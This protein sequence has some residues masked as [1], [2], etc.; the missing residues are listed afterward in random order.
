MYDLKQKGEEFSLL[1]VPALVKIMKTLLRNGKEVFII[2]GAVRDFLCDHQVKDFD[3]ATN[4]TPEQI[5][6]WLKDVNIKTKS[7]GG[8]YGTVLAIE[9]KD[10]FDISTYR[11]ESF[12]TYGLPPKITFVESLD[13]DLIRRDFR[14]NSILYDPQKEI[15]VDKYGGWDDI[16]NHS[17]TMIGDPN[18]RLRE[19]GLRIIRLARFMSKFNLTPEPNILSAVGSISTDVKFR[20]TKVIQLELLKFLNVQDIQKGLVLLFENRI[21]SGIFPLYPFD[22]EFAQHEKYQKLID[23]FCSIVIDNAFTRLFGVLLLFSEKEKL[24]KSHFENLGENLSL[25]MRQQQVLLRLYS[26]WKNFPTSIDRNEIKRW[27]RA[28]GINT[29]E[30]V[31]KFHFLCLLKS[32]NPSYK[33]EDAYLI[34][35]QEIVTKLKSRKQ[36]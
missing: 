26:S 36:D 20:S 28:T 6:E 18:I 9:G 24:E 22:L 17:I 25:S 15:I 33:Q 1:L 3:V 32:K 29:S 4:A 34:A 27:V 31:A 2:G 5:I 7:I 30:M 16:Q 35:I 11:R 13:D 12:H 14:I 8:K 21:L 10:A 19:D 23:L